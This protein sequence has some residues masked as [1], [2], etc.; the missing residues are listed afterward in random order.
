MDHMNTTL[1]E[2]KDCWQKA[3]DDYKAKSS[4][5]VN[6]WQRFM[7]DCD[8]RDRKVADRK[9]ILRGENQVFTQQLDSLG[10]QYMALML[11]G[12]EEKA[13]SIHQEMTEIA[14]KRS[15]N[16]VL[17]N[18]V[19]KV[20]YDEKL[21]QEAE[22]AF[23]TLGTASMELSIQKGQVQETVEDMLKTLNGL[24]DDMFNVGGAFVES[25]YVMRMHQR[26]NHQPEQD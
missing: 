12:L 14:S 6:A 15:A 24:K 3:Y 16:D 25:T 21:L 4:Q 5:F 26:F 8:A 19:E 9:S 11:D 10:G 7:D 2:V 17:I 20:A 22:E 13:A 23:E 18:S 1:Q